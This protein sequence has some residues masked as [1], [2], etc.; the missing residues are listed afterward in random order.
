PHGI[1]L[2]LAYR[3]VLAGRELFDHLQ[4]RHVAGVE[5]VTGEPGGRLY[6]RTLRLPGGGGIVEVREPAADQ[7]WLA[8]RLHLCELRDLTTAG[9][10]MR[11]LFDLDADPYA[12][13]ERLGG[14]PYLGP[15]VAARPGLRVPG[16]A[17]P[18]E[19]ALRA[20]LGQGVSLHEARRRGAALVSAYG[21]VLAT[22]NGELTHLFP[23]A[24]EL[25]EAPLDALDL[26]PAGRT[27]L[28]ALATALADG[29]LS[30]DP[31]ADR[32]E[33]ERRLRDLPGLAGRTA[34]AIRMRA[35]G[36][37]DVLLLGAEHGQQDP[38]P[39]GGTGQP[40]WDAAGEPA[41]SGQERW[42]PWR[43]YATHYLWA[44][45]RQPAAGAYAPATAVTS[46]GTHAP[47]TAATSSAAHAP[48]APGSPAAAH[49]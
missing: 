11:R 43:S 30:L 44:A 46:A 27:T 47:A 48:A 19:L 20:V 7:G 1:P 8:C 24:A 2:R 17:D 3:G 21:A 14:C 34:R 28:R 39:R 38:P 36:D 23:S 25:A 41:G 13:A 45:A 31:G 4:Q 26:P 12:V 32:A 35:L 10:R 49:A 5:E 6:R 33:A 18:H 9:Q 40:A 42:R 15:L 22:A 16:A 37:P 29:S